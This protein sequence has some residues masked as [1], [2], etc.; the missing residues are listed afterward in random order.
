MNPKPCRRNSQASKDCLGFSINAEYNPHVSNLPSRGNLPGANRLSIITAM[1]MLAYSLNRFMEIPAQSIELQLPG[2]YIAFEVNNSLITALL[3]A[4]LAATG[5]DWLLRDH[6]ALNNQPILPHVLLPAVTALAV[7]IPLNQL[8]KGFGWWLG[9]LAGTAAMVL[10]LV[11]EYIAINTTDVRQ[12]LVAAGL[13]AVAFAIYLIL[14]ANLRAVGTRL[15]FILPAIIVATWL[16]S[17]RSLNLRLHGPWVVYESA[18]IALVVGQLAAAIHYWPLTPVRF[19]LI[20][21]GPAYALTSLFSGLIEEKPTRMLLIEP[22]IVLGF[23]WLGALF[24]S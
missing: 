13:S 4:G 16:V 11:G 9:L 8:T 5:A 3:V 24:L 19:G 17:L 21:I 23:S 14:T 18:I 7:G 20:L 22:A 15:F 10:V 2:L 6:P 12:P 1:I